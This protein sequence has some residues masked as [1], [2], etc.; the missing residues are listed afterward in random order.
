MHK[1]SHSK[2]KKKQTIPQRRAESPEIEKRF[3]DN[4][5]DDK[6]NDIEIEEDQ[7][8]VE[9]NIVKKLRKKLADCQKE[10]KEYLD[11]WQRAKADF[12]NAKQAFGKEKKEYIVFAKENLLQEILPVLDS[13][14]LAFANKEAW[15][16]VDKNWRL[17]V[18]YIYSQLVT[19]LK[20]NDCAPID[21]LEKKFNP[22]EHDCIEIIKTDNKEESDHIAEIVQKGYSYHGKVVRPSKVKVFSYEKIK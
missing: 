14:D 7:E 15:E 6:Y 21:S 20:N 11:G 19:V 12:I 9:D 4:G 3:I 2:D 13:F 22:A 17:G 16:K 10:R 1:D 18:E 8:V 5:Q